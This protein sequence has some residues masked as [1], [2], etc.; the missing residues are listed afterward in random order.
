MMADRPEEAIAILQELRDLGFWQVEKDIEA[1][2]NMKAR[3]R[4]LEQDDMY[5][6]ALEANDVNAI[7]Q[8]AEHGSPLACADMLD[9]YMKDLEQS[10]GKP[11]WEREIG[12]YFRYCNTCTE[13][14][15]EQRFTDIRE[16][17]SQWVLEHCQE[18][19]DMEDA[20]SAYMLLS[21]LDQ[22]SSADLMR[23]RVKAARALD[24][25][26]LLMRSLKALSLCQDAGE[27]ERREADSELT[28]LK[29]KNG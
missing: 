29:M 23:L 11:G 8:A 24:D 6:K 4:A 14:L 5:K 18:L 26:E 28:T 21:Q 22:H 2:E 9:R 10:G 17:L 27:D 12:R 19:L 7:R 20:W 3:E 25:P 1:Y 13:I 15:G 16:R